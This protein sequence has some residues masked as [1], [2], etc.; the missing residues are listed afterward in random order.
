MS[1]RIVCAWCKR[2]LSEGSEPTSHGICDECAAAQMSTLPSHEEIQ[3]RTQL[4]KVLA[5]F[6][7][8][9]EA[10]QSKSFWTDGD[11]IYSYGTC[12]LT[13]VHDAAEQGSDVVRG[14]VLN[15]TRYTRTTTQYQNEL[16]K[17]LTLAGENF[18]ALDDA[19]LG[20]SPATLLRLYRETLS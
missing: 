8:T 9:T 15:L 19:P 11:S 12:L 17:E 2:V 20:C 3:M 4:A 7:A 6:N 1:H 18:A 5:A 14:S 13:R 16:F 10:K